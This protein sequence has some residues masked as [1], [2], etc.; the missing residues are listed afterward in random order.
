MIR[1]INVIV[2][3]DAKTILTYKENKEI[4]EHLLENYR[5]ELESKFKYKVIFRYI[6]ID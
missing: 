2:Y 3:Q 1:I 5:E 4:K 6:N